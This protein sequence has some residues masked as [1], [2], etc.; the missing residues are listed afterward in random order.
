MKIEMGMSLW[1]RTQNDTTYDRTIQKELTLFSHCL[2]TSCVSF[3]SFLKAFLHP[4]RLD[5]Q[6]FN[7][8]RNFK[9]FVCYKQQHMHTHF[10]VTVMLV[11]LL[12]RFR[13]STLRRGIDNTINY[14]TV[15][16][17]HTHNLIIG[18]IHMTLWSVHIMCESDSGAWDIITSQ[19]HILA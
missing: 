15:R 14:Y 6:N 16:Q 18:L 1:L 10:W 4:G 19:Q 9:V 12:R 3:S 13:S 5:W 8:N 2:A 7:L 11:F 17:M